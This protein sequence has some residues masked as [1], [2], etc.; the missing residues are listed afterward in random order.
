VI[1]RTSATKFARAREIA[2]KHYLKVKEGRDP[3]AEKHMQVQRASHTFGGLVARYLEQ[4]RSQLRDSSYREIT[5]HLERYSTPLHSL[6]VDA[7]DQRT[8]AERLSAIEK[9]SGAVTANRVRASMS[10]M[11]T[12]GM[13]EGLILANPAA[14]SNKREEKARNRVL[15]DAELRVI[16]QA[17]GDSQYGT[18]V[19]LLILTGQR[20]NEIAR[21]R[22]S[23]IDFDRGVISLPG[24]RTKNGRPHE[25][26]MAQQVRSLL[27]AQS[28][29][30]DLVFGKGTG[31]FSGFSWCKGA[32][33]GRIADG[34]HA[35][36]PWL[37]HDL[38]RTA[39]TGMAEIGI[40][41]RSS[42]LC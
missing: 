18:I 37:L 5:R 8:I 41:P 3:A 12:W 38:R 16:W 36:E 32:L 39:A 28:R 7:V 14:N 21:L 15:V 1:G 22:W 29:D 42:K 2:R 35:L 23:E 9:G 19:K 34:G 6:A 10:A 40:Q 24:E 25:V 30:R 33:D 11:F 17:L 27:E 20:V 4:Q 13:K 26:P 31:P